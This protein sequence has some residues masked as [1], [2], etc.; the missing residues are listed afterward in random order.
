MSKKETFS[1]KFVKAATPSF[2]KYIGN[3]EGAEA[4]KS[5]KKR[6]ENPYVVGSAIHNHWNDGYDN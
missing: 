4:K 1:S 5:G 3:S 6:E 2:L